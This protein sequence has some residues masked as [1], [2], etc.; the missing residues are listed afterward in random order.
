MTFWSAH[1]HSRYSSKDALPSVE[2]V[3]ARAAELG[4]PALGLTDHGNMAGAAQ[5]YT[6]ARKAGIKPLPGTE[7][8]VAVSRE[9]NARSTMHLGILATTA[10][11]YRN[12]VGLTTQA[13]RQFHY[14][15]VLDLADLA[16]AGEDGRLEGLV[17]M[18]GCHFGLLPTLMREGDPTAARN[19]LLALDSWFDQAYVEIQHHRVNKEG[20]DDDATAR[21]LHSLAVSLSLPVLINQDSHYCLP[22][23]RAAHDTMKALMS[24]SDDPDD[25]LFPGD[26]YHMA[27]ECWMTD[28]YPADILNDG[29]AGLAHLAETA[30]VVIPELDEFHLA[31]PDTGG[32][33]D[34][35]LRMATAHGHIAKRERGSIKA[36]RDRDYVKRENDELDI[37]I[38]AGFSGYLLLTKAVCDHMREQGIP[39]R[40][41]GSAGGS[42]L[43]W[44]LGITTLDSIAWGLPFDRFLSTDRTKPP[45]IDI[46][47]PHTRRDE[48][49]AW[50]DS[51]YHV[52]KICTWGQMGLEESDEGDQKGS[53]MVRWKMNARKTGQD[54]DLRLNPAAWDALSAVASHKP[55]LGYGVHAAGLLITPD[56]ESAACIPLQYVA[57]S[58]TMV[59]A[60]GKKDVERMG[61]VK[62][63][64]LGLKTLT[65]VHTALELIGVNEYEIPFT[66]ASTYAFIRSGNT[67]GLFQLEG[68]SSARGVRQLGPR[69]ISDVIAAMALFRPATLKSGATDAY[70][71]R[72]H[73]DQKV[74]ERHEIIMAETRDT[75][76]VLLYQEQ[77]LNVLK[78]LGM[79]VEEIEAARGAIKASNEGVGDA[80][81]VMSRIQ[82]RLV[83]LARGVGMTPHDIAWLN[84]A[85][86]AYAG[87]GFNKAHATAYGILAYQTAWLR[88]HHKVAFW[89]GM[90]DAYADSTTKTWYGN[91]GQRRQ[92]TQPEAYR[93]AAMADGVTMLGPHVN[94][95]K[96]SWSA[97]EDLTAIR[98]GLNSIKGVGQVA[99]GEL[100][101]KAPFDSLEDLALRV[102]PRRVPGVNALG[103]GHTPMSCGGVIAALSHAGALKGLAEVPIPQDKPKKARKAKKEAP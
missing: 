38:G 26:G 92:V 9:V 49:I 95:S 13:H 83:P 87:Y 12:L 18:S 93:M 21:R 103:Q 89:T 33:P 42:L 25:A 91:R 48:V 64:L 8:Y 20:Q 68:G 82:E 29:L 88:R 34:Y 6:A 58:K 51:H 65:A 35:E 102:V 96:V 54:P 78:A 62:L 67:T 24:W 73:G 99:A 50:L 17:V 2:K 28:R 1:T 10:K 85:M 31:V 61:R 76:G 52:S 74:P 75:Y 101:A 70:I 41:R 11:G 45:D 7:A 86:A 59:T 44:L 14:K 47:V 23:D 4:Y 5:L 22:E 81:E 72:R 43:C 30:D 36:S 40:V 55:Y 39:F 53:L 84:D 15:P 100:T 69:K 71:A 79:T 77:A 3:V 56:E 63:D 16:A 66:D 98:A 80:R 27:D 19:L 32:D 46:D 90:L 57:S 60:Y 37:V 97:N 94:R